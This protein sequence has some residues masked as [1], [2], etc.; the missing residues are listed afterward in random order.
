[1][2]QNITLSINSSQLTQIKASSLLPSLL[3]VVAVRFQKLSNFTEV[4][5]AKAQYHA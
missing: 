2:G 3:F 5:L 4:E 1:M